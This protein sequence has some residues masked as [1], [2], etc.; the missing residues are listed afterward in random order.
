MAEDIRWL[1]RLD[2]FKRSMLQL[3]QAVTLSKQRALSDLEQQGLI[4]ASL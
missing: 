2:N 1:Q 4:Q 3:E